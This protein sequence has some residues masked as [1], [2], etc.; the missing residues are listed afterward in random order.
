M[1]AQCPINQSIEV[2]EMRPLT[3]SLL[4]LAL[5]A[6]PASA[7]EEHRELG[8]HQHGHGTLNIAVEKN[9]VSMDLDVPGMDVVGFEHAPNTTDER[10]A[11]KKAEGRLG[12]A[13]V[14]FK[15]PQ[16]AGCKASNAKVTIEAENENDHDAD[17][18]AASGSDGK[19]M[20]STEPSGD[21]HD[22]HAGHNDYNVAYVLECAKPAE[23][24][25]IEFDYFKSFAGA[26][27]LTVNVVTEKAQNTYE[28]TRENPVADLGGMM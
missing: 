20:K 14:L 22:S 6:G 7:A 9:R 23:I 18:N 28:V 16:S 8:P 27:A 11:A 13:L 1:P 2:N 15:V 26:K 5:A 24:T 19:A 12:Q 4:A 17:K 21:K 3:L 25:S 10:A